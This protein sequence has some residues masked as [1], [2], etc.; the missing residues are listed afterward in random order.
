MDISTLI[1]CRELYFTSVI[2]IIDCIF[3]F[4]LSENKCK[5]YHFAL[6]SVLFSS[7]ATFSYTTAVRQLNL[8]QLSNVLTQS[9]RQYTLQ[10]IA[11][12]RME[13]SKILSYQ[14]VYNEELKR[15]LAKEFAR[16]KGI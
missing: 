1:H 13:L 10:Q 12:L 15:Y 16:I 2:A 14:E 8:H 9:I 3:Q 11:S 4:I 5:K 6:K 7:R